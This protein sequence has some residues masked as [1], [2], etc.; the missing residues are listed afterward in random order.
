M[1]NDRG[2]EMIHI[3][4]FVFGG[5][6]FSDHW[7]GNAGHGLLEGKGMQV[8]FQRFFCLIELYQ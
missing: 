6:S 2:L 4:F 1:L 5:V 7:S 8:M 3:V